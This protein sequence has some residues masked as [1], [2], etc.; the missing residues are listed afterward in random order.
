[1]NGNLLL[2]VALDWMVCASVRRGKCS[3]LYVVVCFPY[4]IMCDSNAGS[5]SLNTGCVFLLQILPAAL[6]VVLCI[7]R[8]R[9]TAMTSSL[10]L[11]IDCEPQQ[12]QKNSAEAAIWEK[13]KNYILFS[14]S[15]KKEAKSN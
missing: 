6:L 15:S 14:K 7:L 10:P 11:L 9:K 3:C 8:W 13:I 4:S 2:T 12:V 1:M 5:W